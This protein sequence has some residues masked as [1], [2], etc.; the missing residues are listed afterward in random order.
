MILLLEPVGSADVD[1]TSERCYKY[2]LNHTVSKTLLTVIWLWFS[3]M[4][5]YEGVAILRIF[6]F[7]LF[8]EDL[9]LF[10]TCVRF[11]RKKTCVV[12]ELRLWIFFV[13][14]V[15]WKICCRLPQD[16]FLYRFVY[17]VIRNIFSI[18]KIF[19]CTSVTPSW[20]ITIRSWVDS[21]FPPSLHGSRRHMPSINY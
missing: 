12:T 11:V 3:W 1:W 4:R 9:I 6:A 21:Q 10:A 20:T 19:C 5:K 17:V 7:F 13:F 14:F 8:R 18:G 2:N 15:D 16:V